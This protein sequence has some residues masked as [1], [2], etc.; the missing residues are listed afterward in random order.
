MPVCEVPRINSKF[1]YLLN[2]LPLF[3]NFTLCFY[4]KGLIRKLKT[5][6]V[7]QAPYM[8]GATATK[9]WIWGGP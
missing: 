6:S 9:V 7:Y 3:T 8:A 2:G 5:S 1:V 4:D